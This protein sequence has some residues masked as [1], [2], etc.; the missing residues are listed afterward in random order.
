M[1]D[2]FAYER[3]EDFYVAWLGI[4]REKGEVGKGKPKGQF[5]GFP[6]Q[7]GSQECFK[8]YL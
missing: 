3:D 8:F 6:I 2:N 5:L 1:L 4:A 7:Y